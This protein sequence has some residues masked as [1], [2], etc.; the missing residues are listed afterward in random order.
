M[1]FFS[2]LVPFPFFAILEL[3]LDS[4]ETELTQGILGNKELFDVPN[5]IFLLTQSLALTPRETGYIPKEVTVSNRSM[6]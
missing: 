6:S 1:G 3:T 5:C 4:G 2:E